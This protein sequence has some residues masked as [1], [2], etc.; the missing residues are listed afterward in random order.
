M[1]AGATL[2]NMVKGRV[3]S[4]GVEGIVVEAV[5][6]RGDKGGCSVE[7][8]GDARGVV[9]GVAKEDANTGPVLPLVVRVLGLKR[10]GED[11]DGATERVEGV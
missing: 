2:P 7:D 4:A 1:E 6:L 10:G 11:V 9:W 3:A 5:E 8:E